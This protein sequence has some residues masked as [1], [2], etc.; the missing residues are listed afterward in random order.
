MDPTSEIWVNT[1]HAKKPDTLAIYAP[2]FSHMGFICPACGSVDVFIR[3][4]NPR[5]IEGQC[6]DCSHKWNEQK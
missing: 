2:K 4:N 6:L 3:W 1:N 5:Q